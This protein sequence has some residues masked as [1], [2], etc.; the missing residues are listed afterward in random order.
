MIPISS[1]MGG[2]GA[3]PPSFNPKV[4][5]RSDATSTS[6]SSLTPS[7]T[8]NSGA[9][10]RGFINNVAFPGARQVNDLRDEGGGIGMP[11][12]LASYIPFIVA[13]VVAIVGILLWLKTRK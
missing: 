5:A 12:T 7:T 3:Q 4:D 10:N 2:G 8:S 11:S 9:G 6:S 1:I 13:A